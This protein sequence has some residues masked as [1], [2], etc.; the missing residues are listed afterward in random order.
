MDS[1]VFHASFSFIVEP[2]RGIGS[3]TRSYLANLMSLV[4]FNAEASIK[5]FMN[6]GDLM[7]SQVWP[8]L[9]TAT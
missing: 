3:V 9:F 8:L 4:L 2:F 1:V 7:C 6:T 5:M